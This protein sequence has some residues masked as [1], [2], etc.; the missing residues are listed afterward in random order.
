[1]AWKG[2]ETQK[3]LVGEEGDGL[4]GL[5]PRGS[6]PGLPGTLFSPPFPTH[7]WARSEGPAGW[8]LP[9]GGLAHP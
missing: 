4:G 5:V 1:M 6:Q 8:A 2:A 7:G 3:V 9:P